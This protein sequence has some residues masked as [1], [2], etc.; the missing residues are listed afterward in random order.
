VGL[1]RAPVERDDRADRPARPRDRLGAR[2]AAA[3]RHVAATGSVVALGLVLLVA[4]AAIAPTYA[5]IYAMVDR[6]APAGTATEAFAWLATAV[7]IGAAAGAAVA[8]AAAE[9]AGPAAAFALP[10]GAGAVALL[11]ITLRARTLGG[12]EPRA[13]ALAPA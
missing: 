11:A 9:Q 4:G 2:R 10:G 8:G 3:A 12:D 13:L 7:A 5:R 6:A 1:A